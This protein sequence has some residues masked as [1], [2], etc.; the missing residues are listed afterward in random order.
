[1]VGTNPRDV[2]R[3][4]IFD[5]AGNLSEWTDSRTGDRMYTMGG[6]YDSQ[7]APFFVFDS[8]LGRRMPFLGFRCAATINAPNP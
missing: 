7:L 8:S 5:M 1:M 2:T 3:D 6:H 4:G